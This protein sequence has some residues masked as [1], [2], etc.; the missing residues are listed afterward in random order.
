VETSITTS[1]MGE[2]FEDLPPLP[3][4]SVIKE[5]RVDR[6]QKQ[7]EMVQNQ[8]SVIHERLSNVIMNLTMLKITI[9]YFSQPLPTL[10][11][12]VVFVS[13]LVVKQAVQHLESFFFI[14]KGIINLMS[15][16]LRRPR[17]R[18]RCWTSWSSR[19]SRRRT[20]W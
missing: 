11:L 12:L 7:H 20:D 5:A 1:T 9:E 15:E 18:C 16:V 19:W 8:L 3:R 17:C 10:Y 2:G 6:I 13:G 4:L 14:Y